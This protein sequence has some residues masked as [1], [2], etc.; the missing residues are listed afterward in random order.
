MWSLLS[1]SARAAQDELIEQFML[2]INKK[3]LLFLCDEQERV[4]GFGLCF[5]SIGGALKKS[6]GRLTPLAL[7]KLLRLAKNPKVIDLGLVAI[8]PEYQKAGANA[9]MVNGILQM[10]TS[11]GVEKCETNLNLETNTAVISQWKYFDARQHKRRRSYVKK[12]I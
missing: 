8:R 10:L 3:Y 2:L 11:G 6:G 1:S 4:V 9:I 12:I 7:L 5:P